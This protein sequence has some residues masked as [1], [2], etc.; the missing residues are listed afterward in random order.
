[1]KGSL[2]TVS[3]TVRAIVIEELSP[4]SHPDQVAD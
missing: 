3:V 1:M 4:A 2:A